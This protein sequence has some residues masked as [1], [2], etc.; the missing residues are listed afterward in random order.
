MYMCD[1]CTRRVRR[2]CVVRR[3]HWQYVALKSAITTV[4]GHRVLRAERG[5]G[6]LCR[7]R[8]RR[9]VLAVSFLT[10]SS[11]SYEF[12]RQ[13][14]QFSSV[15]KSTCWI[16]ATARKRQTRR[17]YPVNIYLWFLFRHYFGW[18]VVL[19]LAF[20][21]DS[22]ESR[23]TGPR[24]MYNNGVAYTR[25]LFISR[26][27]FRG[28]KKYIRENRH[29]RPVSIIH[30]PLLLRFASSTFVLC[31]QSHLFITLYKNTKCVIYVRQNND[32]GTK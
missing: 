10:A 25:Y 19:T 5:S 32:G 26:G 3:S 23:T 27:R 9:S 7:R 24:E 4:L 21:R 11:V 28:R 2:D 22:R 15:R 1:H 18:C 31:A 16:R 13:K 8:A 30:V 6:R 17:V 20:D 12:I 14:F 29:G